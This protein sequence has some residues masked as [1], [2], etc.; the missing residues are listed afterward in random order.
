MTPVPEF[1]RPLRAHEVGGTPRQLVL[2]ADAAERAALCGRFDLLTLAALTATL[3]IRREAAGIRISG[4]VAGSGT[5]PCVASGEPVAF[6]V[7]EPV[8]LL[9]IEAAPD[10]GEIELDADDLDV[11]VLDGDVIDAGEIAAQAF[12]L[13]LDPY[14]RL[15]G[16]VTGLL[17]ED[18]AVQARSPFAVLKKG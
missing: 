5:Q 12:A 8:S 18:E 10:S 13:G 9:L 16:S 1:S 17:S 15:P 14:P 2:E 11:D 6:R 4:Q 7:K 3:E